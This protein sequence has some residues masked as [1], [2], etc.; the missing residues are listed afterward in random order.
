MKLE[1]SASAFHNHIKNNDIKAFETLFREYYARLCNY[2][3]SIV[4]DMDAAEEIVQDF[5]YN[6][7]KNR[8][9]MTFRISL[10]SYMYR[11]IK[12]NSLTYLDQVS[13]RRKYAEQ[14]RENS[15]E[16]EQVCLSDQL[17]AKELE[18]II[19]ATLKELPERSSQ[20]F[21]MNRFEGMK[22]HEIA[23]KLSIS[24]KTVEANMSKALQ[25]LRKKLHQYNKDR[26]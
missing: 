14:H 15:S 10:K 9:G 18:S 6:Y 13:V 16:A 2:S 20:V 26:T 22:Y 7:W 4:K 11:A 23:K 21:R 19:D 12:N 1:K 24:A 5:F 17:D 25:A 3:N 8:K